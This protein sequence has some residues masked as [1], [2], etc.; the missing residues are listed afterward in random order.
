MSKFQVHVREIW[1]STVYIEADSIEDAI[2]K[3]KSSADPDFLDP[4]YSDTDDWDSW[5]VQEWNEEENRWGDG[6]IWD[7][8]WC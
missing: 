3:V 7:G 8:S 2:E 1:Y 4:E 6:L 5:M